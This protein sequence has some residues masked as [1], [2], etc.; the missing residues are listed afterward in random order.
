MTEAASNGA[1]PAAVAFI[2]LAILFDVIAFGIVIP[3]LPKLIEAFRHGDTGAAAT[4]Y[5]VFATAWGLMQFVF[6]PL[7]G[8]VS[9]RFGRRPVLLLSLT[10]LGLDYILMALSPNLA[11]LFVGRV[12]SG[13]TAATYST[14]AAYIADVTPPAKRAASFG[15]VG[16]AWGA[17]FIIGP[18]IGGLLGGIDL[19][20]PFWVAAGLTLA[21]AAYGWFVVPESLPPERRST[22]IRWARANPVGALALV[23]DN[24]GLA[25][26]VSM[27]VLYTLAHYS[28]PSVFVL[29]ASYRYGWSLQQ[30]GLTLALVGVCTAIVQAGLIGPAVRWLGE[31]KALLV[32]LLAATAAYAF[33]GLA[34]TG[35]W[36][37]AAIPFGAVSGLYGAAAQSLMTER[38]GHDEQGQLQGVNSSLMGLTGLI[39]PLLFGL[40]FAAGI[41][42]EA[43]GVAP[44]PGAAFL[45]AAL[46]TTFSFVI[47]LRAAYPKAPA[48]APSTPID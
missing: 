23:K 21:N 2:L 44:L 3:V 1:R 17:G 39:G 47:A 32:G 20:L 13:I 12:I 46:L 29:Y 28:L 41:R 11:W 9:D 8:L 27:Q 5:S 43:G 36:F 26:L 14:A 30:V 37:L 6:S 31:R 33:Y 19:R 38:V 22:S 18:A 10:G 25:G 4:T 24:P 35:S 15:Y 40:S 48:T 34:P 45:V 16:A 42:H 7:L